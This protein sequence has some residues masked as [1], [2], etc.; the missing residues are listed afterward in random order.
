MT[1]LHEHGFT[2]RDVSPRNII[3]AS[4]K[5]VFVKLLDF[6]MMQRSSPEERPPPSDKLNTQTSHSGGNIR[7]E[8]KK[9][10]SSTDGHFSSAYF[11]HFPCRLLHMNITCITSLHLFVNYHAVGTPGYTAGEVLELPTSVT[12]TA[13]TF[14]YGVVVYDGELFVH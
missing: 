3:M 4:L 11:N 1:H 7:S 10:F 6:G 2:H 9:W 5:P 12:Q 8:K 13:D 14:S